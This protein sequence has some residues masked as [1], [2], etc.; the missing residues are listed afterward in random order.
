MGLDVSFDL[1][2][3]QEPSTCK[4]CSGH[5]SV[6]LYNTWLSIF[7]NHGHLGGHFCMDLFF[8]FFAF[9]IGLGTLYFKIFSEM[10]LCI[11]D[12][13]YLGKNHHHHRH[14]HHH[15]HHHHQSLFPR[16]GVGLVV[17]QLVYSL[18]THLCPLPC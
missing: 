10:Y 17:W 2:F 1:D 3:G 11:R 18:S 4:S 16:E 9:D 8:C 5:S 6:T 14:H 12:L 7:C 15:H 13:L